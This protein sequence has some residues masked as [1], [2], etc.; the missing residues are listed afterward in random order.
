MLPKNE[1]QD[2]LSIIR[3]EVVPLPQPQDVVQSSVK[4]PKFDKHLKKA[5]GHI[6]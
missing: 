1:K 4:V 5:G 2:F 3:K 6:G